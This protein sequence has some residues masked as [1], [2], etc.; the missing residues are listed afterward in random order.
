M[1]LR[2]A[3]RVWPMTALRVVFVSVMMCVFVRGYPGSGEILLRSMEKMRNAP[4]L[5]V[6]GPDFREKISDEDGNY[7]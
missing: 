7:I 6:R 5:R 2:S 3:A 1:G 4:R